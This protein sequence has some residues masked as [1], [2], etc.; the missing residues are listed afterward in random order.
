MKQI[1]F[2]FATLMSLSEAVVAA[3]VSELEG[4]LWT[5][6]CSV[7]TFHPDGDIL[8]YA[9]EWQLQ[10]EGATYTDIHSSYAEPNCLGDIRL[11]QKNLYRIEPIGKGSAQIEEKPLKMSY[12][13][14][15]ITPGLNEVAEFLNKDKACD[16]SDWQAGVERI[17][18]KPIP[19]LM[20]VYALEKFD[21][22]EM[23]H[24]AFD[25]A[26]VPVLKDSKIYFWRLGALASPR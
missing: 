11:T 20:A 17:C 24:M 26:A 5:H 19:N 2:L 1:A 16:I 22:G 18:H 23:L 14:T 25:E 7:E 3:T 12:L 9:Q 21:E 13:E 8:G 15:R 4:N 6:S 10:V